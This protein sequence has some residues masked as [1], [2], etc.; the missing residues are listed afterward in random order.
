MKSMEGLGTCL[1]DLVCVRCGGALVAHDATL[2]CARCTGTYPVLGGIPL[3]LHRPAAA[4]AVC[5]LSITADRASAEAIEHQSRAALRRRPSALLRQRVERWRRGTLANLDLVQAHA[6]PLTPQPGSDP[7]EDLGILD[8]VA[9]QASG[10][11]IHRLLPYFHQDWC[12]TPQFEEVRS[13]VVDAWRRHGNGAGGIAVLGAGACGL[14]HALAKE[15]GPVYGVDLCLPA[16]LLAR[17]LLSGNALDVALEGAEWRSVHVPPPPPAAHRMALLQAN[18]NALP[19]A[20]GALSVVVTQ[21]LMDLVSSPLWLCAE[22]QRVLRPGGLWINFSNPFSVPGEPIELD[23]PGLAEVRELL[24]TSGF[25]V[26]EAERREF[27]LNDLCG[28]LPER[29]SARRRGPLLRCEASIRRE[30]PAG[31]PPLDARR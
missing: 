9:C 2:E 12:G 24:A 27:A 16:L 29:H 3:L 22:L 8:W 6:G 31:R 19:F 21:Y 1:D 15:A 20:N 4:L 30:P 7:D 13:L 17:T 11:S 28:V 25:E 5:R 10:W 18:V 14:V 26:L 23:R